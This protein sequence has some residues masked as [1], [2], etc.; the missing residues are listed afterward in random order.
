MESGP[1]VPGGLAAYVPFDLQRYPELR[2]LLEREA[3]TPSVLLS[4]IAFVLVRELRGLMHDAW[5]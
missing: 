5:R 2:A 4:R 1:G 3:L